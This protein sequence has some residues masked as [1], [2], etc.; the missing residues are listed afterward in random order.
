MLS[1]NNVHVKSLKT[2]GVRCTTCIKEGLFSSLWK[3]RTNS[4]IF[5]TKNEKEK[6]FI[7]KFKQINK[8][9]V[10]EPSKK[11]RLLEKRNY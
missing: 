3:R 4:D 2:F 10:E 11:N 7:C 5:R 8:E 6:M 1:R 9:T